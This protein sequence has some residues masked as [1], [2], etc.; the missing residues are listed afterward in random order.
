M[1]R[2][3]WRILGTEQIQRRLM[4]K[5]TKKTVCVPGIVKEYL[6]GRAFRLA[7]GI[8]VA[9]LVASPAF[10]QYGGGGMG[11]GSTG[12]GSTGYGSPS[13]GSGKAIGI[14]V[15]AAAAGAGVLYLA[16]HRGS[17]V[18]GCVQ[19]GDD[20]LILVDDKKMSYLLL[21]GGADLLPGERVEIRGKKSLAGATVHTFQPKKLVKNLG[22]CGTSSASV[23]DLSRSVSRKSAHDFQQR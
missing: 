7:M 2:R 12:T 16:W 10:A 13:Y 1:A 5:T 22:S 21:P 18:T 17:S 8:S 14:G 23:D 6:R 15:G 20:G 3:A 9:L 4:I 11:G 19:P